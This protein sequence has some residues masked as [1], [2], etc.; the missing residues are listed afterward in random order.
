PL[1]RG[2]FE[3]QGDN[4]IY[5]INSWRAK[6]SEMDKAIIGFKDVAAGIHEN[7]ELAGSASSY[8]TAIEEKATDILAN[9]L[10]TCVSGGFCFCYP[11]NF[12]FAKLNDN[13]DGLAQIKEVLAKLPDLEKKS[14][15]IAGVT[16]ERIRYK[17]AN[18]ILCQ[19]QET[20]AKV[21]ANRT[22]TKEY[23]GKAL[24]LI[25]S[26]AL[27]Q[28]IADLENISSGM[29]WL[30]DEKNYSGA[31]SLSD[32]Y[33][34]TA[35]VVS[36]YAGRL[37][38]N[39]SRMNDSLSAV[40][41]KLEMGINITSIGD[42]YTKEYTSIRLGIESISILAKPPV[43]EQALPEM[44][45]N[46]T[47][48]D[49]RLGNIEQS[50]KVALAYIERAELAKTNLTRLSKSTEDYKQD[51]NLSE[52]NESISLAFN[53]AKGAQFLQAEAGLAAAYERT[54]AYEA[55]LSEIIPEIESAK[56]EYGKAIVYFDERKK[57]SFIFFGVDAKRAEGLCKS[58]TDSIYP[59]PRDSVQFSNECRSAIDSELQGLEY[60]K[61]GLV[62]ALIIALYL[63]YKWA[64]KREW[65]FVV[66]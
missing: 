6:N 50:G 22:G 61:Y 54:T 37:I 5:A 41:L 65:G 49:S 58:A 63:F 21:I 43:L 66:G 27:S 26:D 42:Y 23:A 3:G 57:A 14:N 44:E 62:I 7:S 60:K 12:S 46:L 15:V 48:F 39:Y 34:N 35:K 64:R 29:I 45:Q 8:L 47:A 40:K 56:E 51:Y 2:T 36:L 30:G 19:Y 52:I 33:F 20:A 1:C 4:F 16:E 53:G 38:E 55:A 31:L 18:N 9:K 32:S 59:S 25:K 17:N 11:I 13:K 24:L 28:K 10:F